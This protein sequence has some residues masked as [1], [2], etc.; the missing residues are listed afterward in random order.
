[1]KINNR[2]LSVR[3]RQVFDLVYYCGFSTLPLSQGGM[4]RVLIP[5]ILLFAPLLAVLYRVALLNFV[6]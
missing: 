3:L 4:L 6:D 2:P 5:K 1:M